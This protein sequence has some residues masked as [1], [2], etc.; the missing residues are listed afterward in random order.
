MRK[1]LF[2]LLISSTSLFIACEKEQDPYLISPTSVGLL[3]KDVKINQ[4]DS[5]FAEDSI[6]KQVNEG[7]FRKNNEIE[8]YDKTGKKLLL[9]EPVQAFDSTSTVGFIQVLDPR[10]KTAKG[11]GT[12]STFKDIVE[13]YTISRIENTLSAAVIFIDDM[14]VYVTIDKKELPAELRYDTQAR[15]QASQIPDHAKIKYFMID[16]D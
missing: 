1:S 15:I 14:N 9:L 2:I 7:E 5:V 6:V 13:N 12:E 8:I 10:F 16:W 4:L 3:T 11:L